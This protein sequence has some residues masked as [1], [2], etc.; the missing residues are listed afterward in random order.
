M[1]AGSI[2]E[3]SLPLAHLQ[4]ALVTPLFWSHLNGC[5]TLPS[6]MLHFV[7]Q[8]LCSHEQ[9]LQA[10][11]LSIG[12]APDTLHVTVTRSPIGRHGFGTAEH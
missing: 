3:L 6:I 9:S 10:E 7:V 8:H 4:S 11:Q 1:R 5:T 2:I 12:A